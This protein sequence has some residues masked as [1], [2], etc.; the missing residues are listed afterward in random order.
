MVGDLHRR[1]KLFAIFFF[2]ILKRL[3]G[4]LASVRAE[5]VR[6]AAAPDPQRRRRQ[7]RQSRQSEEMSGFVCSRRKRQTGCRYKHPKR[8]GERA[9][10][11]P[12]WEAW[13]FFFFLTGSRGGRLAKCVCARA[14]VRVR[15]LA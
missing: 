3:S 4:S 14:L 10:S 15:V 1:D 2:Y 6:G 12:P 11:P 7:S 9:A 13:G 5:T 8:E